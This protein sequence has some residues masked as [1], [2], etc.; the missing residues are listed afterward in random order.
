MLVEHRAALDARPTGGASPYG[1]GCHSVENRGPVAL[2]GCGRQNRFPHLVNQV[3]GRQ[4]TSTQ[5][6]RAHEIASATLGTGDSA[7]HLPPGELVEGRRTAGTGWEGSRLQ[8]GRID[9]EWCRQQMEVLRIRQV[10]HEP[11]DH[12]HVGPPHPQIE[13]LGPGGTQSESSQQAR[14]HAADRTPHP[15]FVGDLA[16]PLGNQEGEEQHG[17]EHQDQGGI[18][19]SLQPLGG[20]HVPANRR[21]CQCHQTG[22]GEHLHGEDDHTDLVHVR[23]RQ[24]EQRHRQVPHETRCIEHEGPEDEEVGDP[25]A[26]VVQQAP[27]TEDVD[28]HRHETLAWSI[29][30]GLRCPTPQ[31]A[32]E[33]PRTNSEQCHGDRCHSPQHGPPGHPKDRDVDGVDHAATPFAPRLPAAGLR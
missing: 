19:G 31:H 27:L 5:E 14:H 22:H 7:V 29:R 23:N 3:L 15:R 11:E 9:A 10:G 4:R 33:T 2:P 6:G 17:D 28:R 24:A 32:N 1:F 21:P 13:R 8:S 12:H 25:D 20:E 18:P 30:P 16:G 26:P